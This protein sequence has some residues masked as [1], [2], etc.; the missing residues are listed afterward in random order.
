MILKVFILTENWLCCILG[1]FLKNSSPCKAST[2]LVR[3]FYLFYFLLIQ[4]LSHY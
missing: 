1:D 2:Y 3:I 4:T